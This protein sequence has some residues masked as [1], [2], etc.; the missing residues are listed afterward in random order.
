MSEE[1]KSRKKGVLF[2][3]TGNACRS[4]IAE[5]FAKMIAP[6]DVQV[7]SAG[8]FPA[9]L[10]SKA[11]RV[12]K[13]IGIDIL[14]QYSK[15]IDE[16]PLD[17]IGT[18]ITLCDSADKLCPSFPGKKRLH[19]PIMDPVGSIGNEE[20]VLQKFREA[21]DEIMEKVEKFFKNKGYEDE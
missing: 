7:F 2:V 15:H 19:W 13:E 8:T 1:S 16:I 3:C 21:R 14:E 12:M 11:V 10:S 20:K 9:G 5:G 6:D 18:V 4:Q 17:E